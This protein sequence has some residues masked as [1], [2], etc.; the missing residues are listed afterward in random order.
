MTLYIKKPRD[1]E[2]V[3]DPDDENSFTTTRKLTFRFR[4]KGNVELF[5][6]NI[7]QINGALDGRE[8]EL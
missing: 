5:A 4:K 2:D 7:R 6:E 1:G 3:P 8:E